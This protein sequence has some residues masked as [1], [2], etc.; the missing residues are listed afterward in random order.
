MVQQSIITIKEA[1]LFSA[2][3]NRLYSPIDKGN[4]IPVIDDFCNDGIVSREG[5][6]VN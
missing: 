5:T 1:P 2:M 6:S 4:A 3:S